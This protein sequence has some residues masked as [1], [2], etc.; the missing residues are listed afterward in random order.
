M[1]WL[2][3]IA[4]PMYSKTETYPRNAADNPEDRHIGMDS[5]QRTAVGMYLARWRSL[6]ILCSRTIIARGA[7][8]SN[9]TGNPTRF[10]KVIGG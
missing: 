5:S 4:L 3:S 2:A 1:G 7:S 6:V 10:S 9:K 8:L